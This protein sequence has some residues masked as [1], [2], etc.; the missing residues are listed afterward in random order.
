MRY[1]GENIGLF[2]YSLNGDPLWKRTWPPQPIYL[3]FGTG[4][5]PI[6]YDGRVY[7][8]QD[9]EKECYLTVLDAK[10]GADV[11]RIARKDKGWQRTS[12]WSTPFIW[13]IHNA[14]RS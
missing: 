9:S 2:V 11:W 14:P 10:T 5:S 4:T 3:D 12:A 1:F 7:L 6:V 8:Q 13:R